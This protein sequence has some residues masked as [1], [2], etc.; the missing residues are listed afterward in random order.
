MF[1]WCHSNAQDM[2]VSFFHQHNH[3]YHNTL[4]W[5]AFT[6][7]DLDPK[8]RK[9]INDHG[10]QIR[11]F[12]TARASNGKLSPR[13]VVLETDGKPINGN[14]ILYRARRLSAKFK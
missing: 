8:T 7:G 9:T 1:L 2:E 13:D 10:D 14:G 11:I 5:R 4:S 3:L 12:E 6:H